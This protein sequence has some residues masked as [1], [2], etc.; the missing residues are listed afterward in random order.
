MNDL[1]PPV[2]DAVPPALAADQ[3]CAKHGWAGSLQAFTRAE[4]RPFLVAL[5]RFVPD[6]GA[7]Q[8]G[9]WREAIHLL[10]T[11]A[12]VL[13]RTRPEAVAWS[14]ILEYEMP[15]E[16]RRADAVLL[17]G[18]AVL[19][20]EFKGKTGVTDPDLDQAHAYARDLRC[21]HDAC[22]DWPVLPV[23][24]P[25]R[26]GHLEAEARDVLVRGPAAVAKLLLSL[27]DPVGTPLPLARFLAADA[28]RPLPTLVE[29][30]RELFQTGDLRRVHRAA[31]V[32]DGA[33]AVIAEVAREAAATGT[34]RLIL[35][36]GVPGA[37][38]TLVGLRVVHAHLLDA[39]A[40]PR[41]GRSPAAPAVFLSGNGPLVE[42]LQYELKG[43]GGGGKTFV[44]GV[45]DYVKHYE[46]RPKI[47]PPEH[48]LVFDEAQ[49]AYDA[50]MVA[51]KH[52]IAR[53]D[54][55][56]KSE[57]EHFISFAS[58]VPG[59]CVIVGLIGGGQE[60]NR[61]E[62]AGLGQWA[63]AIR[64]SGAS[65]T[66]TVHGPAK[67]A[68]PFAALAFQ[69]DA[70][71]SLDQSLRSH[72]ASELHRLVADLL[73]REPVPA[74]DL[75]AIA[76][77]L[78][79]QGHNLLVTRDLEAAKTYLRERYADDPDARF[80]I[81]ASSRDKALVGYGIDNAG[82]K[83]PGFHGPWYGDAEGGDRGRS[84][85]DLGACETEFGAQG[86]ELDAVLLAWGTDFLIDAD[87]RWCTARM[88]P[89]RSPR[90]PISDPWQLRAN[91][92]RVLLT[93]A[94]DA[95][96]VFVPPLA[97]LDATYRRL[98]EAGFRLLGA[99]EIHGA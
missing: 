86:L 48:V 3:N 20:L 12:K 44:R 83:P 11:W 10:T 63:E 95:T 60:I 49:R 87:G 71:L 40:T 94:R 36:T 51:E 24:V 32:T 18:A 28:Y 14:L 1:T 67:L 81:L 90:V 69:P 27:P 68:D 19:V 16:S 75:A 99:A 39:L 21:Y 45:K 72:L 43:A 52:K 33:V 57:P 53:H 46:A 56:A 98:L 65:E 15:M 76:S 74:S 84:C 31:A 73:K 8:M 97:E 2:P 37:G 70:A 6:A 82:Q 35:L 38:K 89:H 55:G 96:V 59:W 85:R 91:A 61:G 79:D 58:R 78:A 30:A 34:R 64:Q 25:T 93:R 80:G 7:P 77:D 29:A 23:L 88:K 54:P 92:Y 42:V 50:A 17:T 62:E 9:A 5:Q 47:A 26:A 4:P 41:Q 66:W 13:L 22:H